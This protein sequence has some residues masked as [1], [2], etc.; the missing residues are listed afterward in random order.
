MRSAITIIG[1]AAACAA[2]A[3]ALPATAA[4]PTPFCAAQKALVDQYVNPMVRTPSAGTAVM[5]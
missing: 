5:T 4:Q 3:H 2:V 1:A